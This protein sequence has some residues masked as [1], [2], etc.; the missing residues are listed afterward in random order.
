[1]PTRKTS[2]KAAPRSTFVTSS[3]CRLS[4]RSTKTPA[5]AENAIAGTRKLNRRM[6]M[7]IFDPL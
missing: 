2:T 4:T 6:L 3:M 5:M 7:A 1:M